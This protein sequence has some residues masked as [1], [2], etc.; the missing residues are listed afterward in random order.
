M[1]CLIKS[2]SLVVEHELVRI[3]QMFNKGAQGKFLGINCLCFY[4]TFQ[5][6]TERLSENTITPNFINVYED[7]DSLSFDHQAQKRLAKL[8]DILKKY[9]PDENLKAYQ[10]PWTGNGIDWENS[11]EHQ[12]Y[13]NSFIE[14]FIVGVKK[15]ILN[16]KDQWKIK[17]KN[18]HLYGELLEHSRQCLYHARAFGERREEMQKVH[19]FVKNTEMN[20]APLIVSGKSGAGKSAFI[21]SLIRHYKEWLGKHCI[22]VFRFLGVTPKS[23]DLLQVLVSLCLQICSI[24]NMDSPAEGD[25]SSINKMAR[26]F[27][28]ILELVS[29]HHA[30]KKPLV[31]LLDG[32]E[33]LKSDHRAD[34]LFWLPQAVPRNVYLILSVNSSDTTL[35]QQVLQKVKNKKS[36]IAIEL[37]EFGESEV[38]GVVESII[39]GSHRTLTDAQR[40]AV[41]TACTSYS[42]PL[43]IRTL[44]G[45]AVGWTSD[46]VISQHMLPQT[47]GET[48]SKVLYR[49]E[50]NYGMKFVQ[51][52][53][54]YICILS[55]G[56][57]EKELYDVMCSDQEVLQILILEHDIKSNDLVVFDI[58]S[59]KIRAIL[60]DL[61]VF[62][63]KVYIHGRHLIRWNCDKYRD[64]VTKK[65]FGALNPFTGRNDAMDDAIKRVHA[66]FSAEKPVNLK[67]IVPHGSEQSQYEL[68]SPTMPY[69]LNAINCRKLMVLPTLIASSGCEMDFSK[70]MKETCLCYFSFLFAKL[71]AFHPNEVFSDFNYITEKDHEIDALKQFFDITKLGIQNDPKTFALELLGCMPFLDEDYPLLNQLLVDAQNWVERVDDTLL[72]VPVFPSFPSPLTMCKAKLWNLID[73]MSTDKTGR[74][75][76]MKNENGYIEIWDLENNEFVFNLGIRFDKVQPNVFTNRSNVLGMNGTELTVWEIQSGLV[77]HQVDVESLLGGHFSSVSVFCCS[78]DFTFVTIHTS[79]EEFNQSLSV[80]HI[81]EA[82]LVHK[83]SEFDVKDEFFKDS[84]AFICDGEFHKMAFV[85]ARSEVVNEKQNADFVKFKIFSTESMTIEQTIECGE[86]KFNKL[87]LKESRYAVV[88]W[89]DCSFDIY[90]LFRGQLAFTLAAPDSRLVIQDCC[91]TEDNYLVGLTSSLPDVDRKYYALWFWNTDE[92][93]SVNLLTQSYGKSEETPKQ[94][95]I[96]EELHVAVLATPN[97]TTLSVWD[98]PN[99]ECIYSCESHVGSLDNILKAKDPNQIY[100]CSNNEEVVKLWD[101]SDVIRKAK[102][103]KVQKQKN[104]SRSIITDVS[105]VRSNTTE[106]I[107]KKKNRRILGKSKSVRFADEDI[108]VWSEDVQSTKASEVSDDNLDLV[109]LTNGKEELTTNLCRDENVLSTQLDTM[110]GATHISFAQDSSFLILSSDRYKNLT[111]L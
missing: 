78:D 1:H 29:K 53:M 38:G 42:N 23:E 59:Q 16:A 102:E 60:K 3:F 67:L 2:V 64:T 57:S 101:L 106:G 44:C 92:Q 71:Q 37:G 70:Q 80:I 31:L 95:L 10:L 81:S 5:G 32:L 55:G 22:T 40:D 45:E 65:C 86:K 39:K 77:V 46:V 8:R 87:L 69:H 56:M 51:K 43:Y 17:N 25:H 14:D 61:D 97:S 18:G 6:L 108:S 79:D 107:L 63:T 41:V 34:T 19:E 91:L 30:A 96:L 28:N 105:S 48:I 58:I 26:H 54:S 109:G 72:I 4:R 62:V 15:L 93:T 12:T 7:E 82:K 20:A 83:I 74:L 90:D 36:S 33:K 24:Y 68:K 111:Y 76:V 73:I 27:Q 9:L 35:H 100:S 47:A 52:L 85:M 104:R 49:L 13:L 94:F 11:D 99:S 110:V 98:L 66:L 50:D 21:A 84:A 88:S 89:K 103:D 75:G